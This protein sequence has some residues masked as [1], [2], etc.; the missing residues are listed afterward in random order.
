MAASL[1]FADDTLIVEQNAK[2]IEHYFIQDTED[3]PYEKIITLSRSI[4]EHRESYTT[5]I[6][7]KTFVLLSNVANNKGEDADAFQFAQDGLSLRGLNKSIKFNLLLKVAHGFYLKEKYDQTQN[8]ATSV[9]TMV[10]HTRNLKYRLIALSY[11]AVAYALQN[12]NNLALSDLK[13]VER[14]ISVNPQ[15]GDHL[16]LLEILA[17]AHYHLGDYQTSLAM[18][19]KLLM[20]RFDLEKITNIDETYLHLA[21]AYLR[22]NLLDDAYNAYWEAKKHSEEK[23]APIRVAYA[24][25]G[26]AEVLLRQKHFQTSYNKLLTAS[27]TFK[28]KG[29]TKPYLTT[30]ILL[31]E[32]SQL[33][34]NKTS[35]YQF[36]QQAELVAK[37]IKL[38]AEQ[39]KLLLLLSNMHQQ[40]GDYQKALAL[41][42]AY[43][44]LLQKKIT[45][46]LV[47]TFGDVD[48]NMKSRSLIFNLAEQSKLRS[49]FNAKY[50]AQKEK[51][52]FLSFALFALFIAF[53][54]WFL[55]Q[56]TLRLNQ[57][58]DEIEQPLY[59]LANPAQTK[60]I[61]QLSYKM[62][63]KFDYPLAVG[64]LSVINWQEL[65]FTFSR[66]VMLEVSRT[67]ASLLNE[68]KGEFDEAGEINGGEYLLL[69]PHQKEVEIAAK[70]DKLVEA[71]NVRFFANLG[72]YSV[73]IGYAFGLPTAQDIDPY[74]FLSRL[75]ESIK[76]Q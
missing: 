11:R 43:L 52:Y 40:K 10:A 3:L 76:A 24:E 5:E 64:Y 70:L 15:Y 61:Y 20:L 67:L 51:I 56:R 18:Q 2:D 66:K 48:A 25:L 23:K 54:F 30:L 55:K 53:A 6:I 41:H 13:Q 68:A 69:C 50:I 22:L 74:I 27:A 63:R 35:F 16:S 14:L 42:K 59:F 58:Y 38:S 29:L 26:L 34:N 19:N 45:P 31:A 72:D 21:R 4:I 49:Q 46:S 36:I 71:I 9:I 8:I 47:V 44:E 7:G 57:V 75:S 32:T 60:K 17:T 73:K 28:G 39:G 12:K 65:S 37:N 33:L 1:C 62:A